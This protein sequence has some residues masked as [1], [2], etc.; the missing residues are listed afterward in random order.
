[1]KFKKIATVVSL[2]LLAFI[3]VGCGGNSGTTKKPSP[4][5]Q[6][7]TP[8]KPT[9]KPTT[10]PTR[11]TQQQTT[12]EE[13]ETSKIA[14]LKAAALAKL[15]ELVNPVIAKISN[16]DIKTAVQNYYDTEKQYI[17]G[18]NDLETA[19]EAANKVASDTTTFALN[20]LK[21]L[22]VEKIDAIISPLI[23]AI[24]INSL[25]TSVQ[26]FYDNEMEK[27]DGIESLSDAIYLF[28]EIIDD[29]KK[30][31]KDETEEL[32]I[33]LKNDALEELDSYITALIEK[34]PYSTL[35]TDTE[36]FYEEELEKLEAV[37][38][39][40]GIRPCVSEIKDD[41]EDYV[42]AEM[43]KI[44]I[45]ELSDLI[46]EGLEKLPN[47]ELKDDLTTFKNTEI[48]KLNAVDDFE[49]IPETL[50]TV[51]TE[52]GAYIKQLLA[53]IVK[54]YIARLTAIE[55]A[56]AYDYLPEAM[57]PYYQGNVV[58]ASS[59]A[60]D[61]TSFTN[62]ASIN[63]AGYGEQ[64]Q[65]VV[66]NIN[67]SIAMAKVFNI[68]QTA[69]S[70]AGNA[71][72]IYL[73]NSYA[74]EMN[75]EFSGS[76]YTGLFSYKDG[77]LK[78]YIT[79]TES[80][81]VPIAGTVKPVIRMEYDLTK[82]AKGMFISLGDAY[83]VKYVITDK[84]YEMASTYGITIKGQE[85]TRTSYLSVVEDNNGKITGHIYEYT[86]LNEDD[87]IQACADF[88]VENGYVSVVGNKA[89]GM[90]GFA[91]YVN[92]LYLANSGRLLGYEVREEKTITVPVLGDLTGTYH[93]LWFNLWDI[94][95][96][97]TI[98]VTDKTDANQSSRSTVDVYLNGSSTLF[99]PTYNTKL[100]RPT[101]RK[102]DIEYRSRFYYTYD[103][104]NDTYVANEVLVPM[105][106]IQEGDNYNSFESDI[107]ADNGIDAS[108]IINQSYLTKIL[109]DYDTLIDIFIANKDNMSS[110][111]IIEYLNQ[112]E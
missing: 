66:E 62:V 18:I 49:D 32:I 67:Q 104:E 51:L 86:T 16:Q 60:Y 106:F 91:G 21:P 79:M 8:A 42:L 26:A 46:D 109:A 70:S 87:K 73:T 20:A 58:S 75:Y 47:Q 59:I 103:S 54:D 81:T 97:E 80:V 45:K 107:S 72:D 77:L 25:K 6:T 89:S 63:K 112:Y 85:V 100:T 23:D 94:D 56:T 10:K 48:A 2:G 108:V 11:T 36:E 29:V 19:K 14:K 15:D 4:T 99:S 57:A 38:T 92:E 13:S 39:L 30:F 65:M 53:S 71:V 43:K 33:E 68:A 76:G 84:S 82:D 28:D 88:Y 98:K 83:K 37:D 101:S 90:V 69:L 17:N 9:T 50:E 7:T 41:L 12:T 3:M 93:T 110:A 22:V 61:F 24:E 95:E 31:I 5:P 96:I 52:T 35:K 102:Y 111:D 27:I 78:F 74:E 40:E 34:I 1:M 55:S 64:W 44:A 105:M